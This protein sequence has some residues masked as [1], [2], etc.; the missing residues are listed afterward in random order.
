MACAALLAGYWTVAA[1]VIATDP[2][3]IYPW[4]ATA[5]VDRDDV[6]DDNKQAISA[7]LKNLPSDLVMVGASTSIAYSPEDLRRAFPASQHPVNLSY[8]GVRPAD[9]KAVLDQVIGHSA[10]RHVII[11]LDWSYGL[12]PREQV[13]AFPAYLYNDTVL[14]D[15]RMVNLNAIKIVLDH[16]AGRPMFPH[17]RTDLALIERSYTG[18]YQGFHSP[19]GVAELRRATVQYR[20]ATTR[21]SN[22]QCSGLEALT[23]Q[24]VPQLRALLHQQRRVDL[25]VP[26]YSPGFYYVQAAAGNNQVFR[27]QVLLRRCVVEATAGM[28][29]LNIY[30]LDADRALTGDLR[31]YKDTSHLFGSAALTRAIAGVGDPTYRLTPQNV[32]AYLERLERDVSEF[33]VGSARAPGRGVGADGVR[34]TSMGTS[35]GR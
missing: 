7:I 28:R 2:F 15:L 22:R 25:V 19:E 35:G 11:W 21:P 12:S 24:L 27:D 23:G 26:P 9:R 14:D 30:A 13:G 8:G 20:E 4:G 3:D 33:S 1:V 34:L 29:G 18:E 10:A 31:N 32:D 16:W 17:F 6:T 5:L